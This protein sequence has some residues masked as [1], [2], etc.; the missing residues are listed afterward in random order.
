MEL[1]P[2]LADD[3]PGSVAEAKRLAAEL[4]CDN[5]MIKV[6]GTAAGV[7]AFQELTDAGI[8][9]NVTLLFSLDQYVAVANAYVAALRSRHQRGEKLDQVASVASFFV[10]R[11]DSAI[12]P[13][14]QAK[15][16]TSLV[17]KAGIANCKVVYEKFQEIF[18]APFQDLRAAR[19][20]AQRVL[21][22]STSTK[23]PEFSDVLY[24][25]SLLG[26]DTVNTLPPNTLLAFLDHGDASRAQ[27]LDDWDGAQ[28]VVTG[29]GRSW[30]FPR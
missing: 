21:W 20:R 6:P 10:S 26:K 3:A 16:A 19:A 1:P 17:G 15:G 25:D 4:A 27:I 22:A 7:Q 23:N 28:S 29:T 11:V 18:G 2:E 9:V 30:D 5:I 13:L 8:C 24:V 14:L 12:D